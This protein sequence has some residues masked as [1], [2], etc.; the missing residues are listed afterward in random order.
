MICPYLLSFTIL[1]DLGLIEPPGPRKGAPRPGTRDWAMQEIG[2]VAATY[3]STIGYLSNFTVELSREGP[4]VITCTLLLALALMAT[5]SQRAAVLS[6]RKFLGLGTV[7]T[8]LINTLSSMLLQPNLD[9]MHVWLPSLSLSFWFLQVGLSS[10][11]KKLVACLMLLAT[12][13]VTCSSAR[14]PSKTALTW[15]ISLV[16]TQSAVLLNQN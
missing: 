10:C 8:V 4:I 3:V 16:F 1:S 12:L 13:L 6:L 5:G 2:P 7:L 9:P 15:I 11:T 14:E